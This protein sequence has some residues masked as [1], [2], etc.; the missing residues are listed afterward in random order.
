MTKRGGRR[1][2]DEFWRGIGPRRRRNPLLLLWRWRRELALLALLA[3]GLP[4]LSDATDPIVGWT[5]LVTGLLAVTAWEPGRRWVRGVVTEHRL[6]VGMIEAGVLSWRRGTV[7]AV[8][9]M[10]A[11]PRG[12]RFVLWCPAGVD[13]SAFVETSGLLAAATWARSVE[14]DRHPRYSQLV[15]LRVVTDTAHVP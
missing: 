8:L 12:V 1:W 3:C 6:R 4:A 14:V 10:S 11:R 2:T 13:A 5:V 15:V 9:R 7:P